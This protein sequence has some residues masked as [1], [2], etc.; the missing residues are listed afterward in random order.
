MVKLK[1]I[2]AA[3]TIAGSDSGGGAGVQADLKTFSAMG[4]HGLSAVTC[5]TAQNP[6]TVLDVQ[7]TSPAML[8]RQLD[9]IVAA[10]AP[11]AMKTG[12]LFSRRLI[13]VV[14]CFAEEHRK[15]PLIVDPVMVA[16][17]GAILLNQSA[18]TALK[19]RLLPLASLITP[20]VP[21][22]EAIVGRRIKSI[23]HQR[24]A[25]RELFERTGVPIVIKGGH[26]K[27][28]EAADIFYDGTD[29]LLLTAPYLRGIKT[30]GTGCTFSAAVAAGLALG[31]DLQQA[32]FDAKQLV[33]QAIA[34]SRRVGKHTVLWPFA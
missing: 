24:D 6:S 18:V 25:V 20:N 19:N 3:L 2:P 34:E 11:R 7:P 30:H 9:A 1:S 23:E 4:V 33:T 28:E 27:G 21:E 17:S 15:I 29:E 31:V 10:F 12:M 14:I 13:D 16:T 26:V 32:V 8:R 22:A 5:L